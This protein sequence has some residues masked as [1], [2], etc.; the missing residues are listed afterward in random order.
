[1]LDVKAF[2]KDPMAYTVSLVEGSFCSRSRYPIESRKI[3]SPLWKT[4]IETPKTPEMF[5][6]CVQSGISEVTTAVMFL[7]VLELAGK[8]FSDVSLNNPC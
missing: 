3:I 2:Y 6:I 8:D 1:M 7:I 5:A 4:P